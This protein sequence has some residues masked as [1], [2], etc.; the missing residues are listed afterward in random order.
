MSADDTHLI[1]L[2]PVPRLQ[3]KIPDGV[4]GPPLP[5]PSQHPYVPPVR[6]LLSVYVQSTYRYT[7]SQWSVPAFHSTLDP[8]I[9]T[10]QTRDR[11]A[12]IDTGMPGVFRRHKR[13]V[14]R[15]PGY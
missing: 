6:G 2:R 9:Q 4:V 10:T 1:F 15:P 12:G 13:D 7:A 5:P 3:P 14:R 11:E 8:T